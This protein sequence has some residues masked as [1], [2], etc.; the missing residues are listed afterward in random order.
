VYVLD[1]RLQGESKIPRCE[2]RSR[3]AVYLGRSPHHAQSV[4]GES[5]LSV[6]RVAL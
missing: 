4:W 1:D 2:P 5:V 3:A 6:R